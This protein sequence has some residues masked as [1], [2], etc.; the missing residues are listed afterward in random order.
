VFTALNTTPCCS[1][2]ALFLGGSHDCR[3]QDSVKALDLLLRI[4]TKLC[5]AQAG[6]ESQ[7]WP[8][9]SLEVLRLLV[10]SC[11]D[12]RVDVAHHA[13]HCLQR[14]LQLGASPLALSAEAWD[15]V[16]EASLFPMVQSLP[17]T[18]SMQP[19]HTFLVNATVVFVGTLLNGIDK[20]TSLPKFEQQWRNYLNMLAS[21]TR[22]EGC[23]ELSCKIPELLWPLLRKMC[24]H[25]C[26]GSPGSISDSSALWRTTLETGFAFSPNLSPQQLYEMATTEPQSADPTLS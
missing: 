12:S 8:E 15:E 26:F 1:A 17:S 11:K 22:L 10:E 6:V 3:P 13:L 21:F 14:G 24:Q 4:H 5:K 16:L 25:G 20:L 18:A 19:E 7:R 2:L 9:L 23:T